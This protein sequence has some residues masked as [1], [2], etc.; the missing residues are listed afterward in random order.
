MPRS[1]EAQ[2]FFHAVY[3]AVQEIPYGK[4]TTYGHIAMLLKDLV[5]SASV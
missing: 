1:D 2:A 3:S 4:V 5:K